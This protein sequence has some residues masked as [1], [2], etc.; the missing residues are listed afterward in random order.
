LRRRSGLCA[1]LASGGAA[2]VRAD[3]G[4]EIEQ[5][6]EQEVEQGAAAVRIVDF[7]F[8]PASVTVSVGGRVTWTNTGERPHTSTSQAGGWDSGR[9]T[10]G[11]TFSFT[12]PRAGSF[13]YICTIHPEMMATVVVQAAAAPAAAAPPTAAGPAVQ[14]RRPVAAP[15][16][17]RVSAA[18]AAARPAAAPAA[19]RPAAAPARPAAAP[20][21]RPAAQPAAADRAMP[22]TGAG[23]A[24]DT[25]TTLPTLALAGT[26]VLGATALMLRRRK[27]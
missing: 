15:P 5:A 12:F 4:E 20:M 6:A 17:Q 22:R 1:A 11:Q 24:A 21:V 23:I 9:L 8:M 16:T 10:T 13:A 27:G 2:T 7:A 25:N 14:P 19:Q 18:P 3:D 26:L